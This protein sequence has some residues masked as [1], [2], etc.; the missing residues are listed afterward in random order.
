MRTAGFTVNSTDLP[1]VA[2]VKD[3]H[4]VPAP[5]APATPP[6]SAAT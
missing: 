2:A 1:D 4:G 5:S 3:K 6:S